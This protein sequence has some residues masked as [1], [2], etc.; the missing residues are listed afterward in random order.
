MS[1]RSDNRVTPKDAPNPPSEPALIAT[2]Y[3]HRGRLQPLHARIHEALVGTP[4]TEPPA[5]WQD[6]NGGAFLRR[7]DPPAAHDSTV[8]QI[9][10]NRPGSI[11]DAWSTM[12]E[13]LAGIIDDQLMQAV[14]GYTLLYQAAL[15]K[16]GDAS[17]TLYRSL[18]AVGP[19][20]ATRSLEPLASAQ[21][22][23][24]E[25]WLLDV[26]LH[27]DCLAAASVYV[28]LGPIEQEETFVREVLYGPGASLLMP[29]LI[30]HKGY[31]QIRQ[32]RL[33]DLEHRYTDE[34]AN[35]RESA[36]RVLSD[37]D[38]YALQTDE[39]DCLAQAYNKLNQVVAILGSLRISMQRQKHNYDRWRD[40][41]G[42][43]DILEYHRDHLDTAVV[44]LELLVAEG[45]DALDLAGSVVDMVQVRVDKAQESR[46]M[47]FG[48]LL[49]VL[50]VALTVPTVIDPPVASELIRLGGA[51]PPVDGFNVLLLLS[52]RIA[53]TLVLV[54]LALAA[55]RVVDARNGHRASKLPG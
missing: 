48:T 4:V 28:G 53:I 44:E 16:G 25:L 38:L 8:L 5:D 11:P 54:A 24:G 36:G 46:Q 10:L 26:P 43:N 1:D 37:L 32:Y 31:H 23:G 33:G 22:I 39:L 21:M 41:Q 27:G 29:D 52:V 30:A 18:H 9:A 35:V 13:R 40:G 3:G 7:F 42:S 49:T 34:V 2:F 20:G 6:P 45:R 47:R 17:S 14:W 55:L 51:T 50:A 19:A 12:R 15:P